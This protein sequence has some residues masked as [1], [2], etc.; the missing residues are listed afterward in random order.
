MHVC[1]TNQTNLWLLDP[2]RKANVGFAS[3]YIETYY[4]IYYLILQGLGPVRLCMF[5]KIGVYSHMELLS[6]Q[7]LCSLKRYFVSSINV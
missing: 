1:D 2:G 4:I 5:S 3:D 7:S 6:L